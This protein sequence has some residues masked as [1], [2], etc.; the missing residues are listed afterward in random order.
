MRSLE[1]RC[2][3]VFY[4]Q[5]AQY[6]FTG[7]RSNLYRCYGQGLL[8]V[9]TLSKPDKSSYEICFG[10]FSLYSRINWISS[11]PLRSILQYDLHTTFD[12]KQIPGCE[13]RYIH[14]PQRD[15]PILLENCVPF[16]DT[17]TTHIQLVEMYE[18]M[19]TNMYS[20]IRV[21]DSQKIVPYILA[22]Q[23]NKAINCITAIEQQNWKAF[24]QNSRNI[25]G[26]GNAEKARSIANRLLPY[27]ILREALTK[28]ERDAVYQ[29]LHSNHTKNVT[30]LNKLGIPLIASCC[31]QLSDLLSDVE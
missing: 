19:D 10:V 6:G 2:R 22:G 16:F 27:I 9:I 29:Y 30:Q 18:R 12:I 1:Y 3:R 26:Y 17:L 28:K 15:I 5:G 8:Q 13:E 24:A 25:S 14:N 7:V 23:Y 20:D 21:N 31:V 11:Y 4:E